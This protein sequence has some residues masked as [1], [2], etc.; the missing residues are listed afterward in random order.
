MIRLANEQELDRVALLARLVV[1]N[2]HSLGIDQ[3]SEKYPLKEHFF[4]DYHQS[5]LYV[6]EEEGTILAAMALLPENDPPYLTIPFAK[7]SAYVIHRI[8]VHPNHMKQTI[9]KQLFAFAYDT[10]RSKNVEWLKI[11]THPDNFRMRQFLEKEGFLEVG[12]MPT[13]HRIGYQKPIIKTNS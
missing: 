2:L 9:G 1:D 8:M 13:I 7:G 4:K 10:L 3:W 11:D 6:Y 12:Y 5:G